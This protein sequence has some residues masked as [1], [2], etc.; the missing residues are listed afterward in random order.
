MTRA[1]IPAWILESAASAALAG[2]F[3]AALLQDRWPGAFDAAVGLSALM[4]A[5]LVAAGWLR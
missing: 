1:A 3:A 4:A 2:M 5:C